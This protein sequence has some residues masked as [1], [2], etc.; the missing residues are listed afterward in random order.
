MNAALAFAQYG[1]YHYARARTL[2]AALSPAHQLFPVQIASSSQT[3]AWKTEEQHQP[4]E[5]ETLLPGCE[6]NAS[7]GK[8]FAAARRFF[9]HRRIEVA[10]LPSY[11]PAS[12]FGLLM[13][14]KATGVRCVMMNESHAGTERGRGW[15]RFLKRWLV[16]CFDSALVGGVPHRRHFASLGMPEQRIFTGYDAV[17]NDYFSINSAN[18]RENAGH[19][20]ASHKLPRRYI[21]NLG[22]M[23]GKKNLATLLEAY[24]ACLKDP[25]ATGLHL[26]FV[27]SGREEHSLRALAGELNLTVIDHHD[28]AKPVKFSENKP[29]VH[30][31]GFRQI[32]E[33]PVFYALAEA[34]VLPSLYEEWGLVVNEAMAC[35]LPVIVSQ[36]AGC[37]EDLVEDGGNGFTFDPL[38]SG[39]LAQKILWLSG[40]AACRRA[41]GAQSRNIIAKWGCDN[42]ARS[43]LLAIEAARAV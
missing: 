27:G 29:V 21:L 28:S 17:D 31:Y 36:A 20:R 32:D 1:P 39:E 16:R 22:R 38:N 10:F 6:D 34:F 41:M 40:N 35:G 2:A 18:A 24:A 15:K 12:S 42:F 8:S 37:A 33:S 3:Y 19:Y 25:R 4:M 7:F 13:A 23:V 26:V 9:Q 5:V 43:A 30:F 11:A 14:A